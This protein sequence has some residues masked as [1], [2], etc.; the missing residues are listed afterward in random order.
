M[1]SDRLIRKL[2]QTLAMTLAPPEVRE[3]LAAQGA[4]PVG[5]SPEEFG[6]FLRAEPDKWAAVIK[7]A[8]VKA[9]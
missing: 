5:S 9:E 4:K 3:H 8:G 2:Q 1:R 6:R 7:S